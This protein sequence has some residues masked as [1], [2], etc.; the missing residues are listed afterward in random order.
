MSARCT[1]STPTS[2]RTSATSSKPRL[3]EAGQTDHEF[4]IIS[5]DDDW[6]R[7]TTDAV[8][9]QMRDAGFNVKRTVIPGST[10]WND[11]TKYP[12]SS[13]NW[14]GRPLGVQVY[15][16]AYI[17]GG[18]WNE[19]AWS[20]PDFDAGMARALATPD[21]DARSEIMAE[22]ETLLRDSGIIIQPYWRS[23][24]RSYREGVHGY[25]AHQAFEQHLDLVWLEN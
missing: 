10:F 25:E 4:D 18:A 2:A 19:T 13:T 12:F 7:N 22:L 20:N 21:P 17:T 24:Y 9:A 11:W 6:L 15:A 14:N 23:V 16:L 8:A 1:S 5:V 3:E